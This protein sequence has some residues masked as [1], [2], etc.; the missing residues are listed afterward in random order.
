MASFEQFQFVDEEGRQE[1]Y[2]WSERR[3]KKY[4]G[5]GRFLYLMKIFAID[6]SVSSILLNVFA[7][8]GPNGLNFFVKLYV[9]KSTLASGSHPQALL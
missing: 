2:K 8:D 3:R 6:K 4:R 7:F 5:C 9:S 1:M